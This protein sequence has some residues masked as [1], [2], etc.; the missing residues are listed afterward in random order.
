MLIYGERTA[1]GIAGGRRGEKVEEVVCA[2]HTAARPAITNV[3]KDMIGNDVNES[4]KCESK[5]ALTSP[6][7]KVGKADICKDETTLIL[8]RVGYAR[9]L[10]SASATIIWSRRVV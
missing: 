5:D 10:R 1:K 4:T 8:V 9:V 6:T 3:E 7:T 2:A